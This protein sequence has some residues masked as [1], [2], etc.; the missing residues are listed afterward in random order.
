MYNSI[1]WSILF[2]DSETWSG[3]QQDNRAID[4][5]DRQCMRNQLNVKWF[6]FVRNDT[7]PQWSKQIPASAS[8]QFDWT[9]KK[10]PCYLENN[11]FFLPWPKLKVR[12]KYLKS[13]E[14]QHWLDILTNQ[15][16]M[17]KIQ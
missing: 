12:W 9:S 8:E 16:T 10:K 13:Q 4:K 5:H 14:K 1:V 7:I 11:F 6:Q 3:K 17:Y 2:C 15:E